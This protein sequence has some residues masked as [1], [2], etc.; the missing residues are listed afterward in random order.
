LLLASIVLLG[1]G[2]RL[3]L[4]CW[5]RMNAWR[6]MRMQLAERSTYAVDKLFLCVVVLYAGSWLTTTNP[7]MIA[8]SISQILYRLVEFRTV[9]LFLLLLAALRWRRG[10]LIALVASGIV[11]LPL[12]TGGG[13]GFA[14]VFLVLVAAALVEGKGL[15]IEGLR[16]RRN[17]RTFALLCIVGLLLLNLAIMWQGAV[18]SRWRPIARSEELQAS[19]IDRIAMFFEVASASLNDLDWNR[20]MASL[21]ER[22][23]DV[24]MLLALTLDR[25]PTEVPHEGGE[26]TARAIRHIAMPRFLFPD[27]ENLGSDS[28]LVRRFAGLNVAGEAQGTSIGLG[29]LIEFY[30]DY[31][32]I[33]ML[34]AAFLFGAFVGSLHRLLLLVAPSMDIYRAAAAAILLQHFFALDAS[35]AKIV[36]GMV[37][38]YIVFGALLLLFGGAIHRALLAPPTISGRP[39]MVGTRQ[40]PRVSEEAA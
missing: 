34:C 4:E 33:G 32:A 18:K 1:A 28:W 5:S 19:R 35:L 31:G 21:A 26:L 3:A 11:A 7:K 25:V 30:V 9:F 23:S 24:P 36:G 39:A 6:S 16:S 8:Y 29:Y 27:K 40:P 14:A 2:I 37:M 13:S 38:A 15:F 22:I 10:R 12:V 20:G 17:R